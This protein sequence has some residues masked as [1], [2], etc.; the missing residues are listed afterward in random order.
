M[1]SQQTQGAPNR[2]TRADALGEPNL[3]QPARQPNRTFLIEGL[4]TKRE[5]AHYCG[6]TTRCVDNWMSKGLIPY[7][8][9]NRTVRFRL[10]N[11]E[12]HLETYCGIVRKRTKR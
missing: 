12:A 1:K 9:I 11:V 6:V 10:A 3:S 5:L 7:L 2:E 8:K 4:M